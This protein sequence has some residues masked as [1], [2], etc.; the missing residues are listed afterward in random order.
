MQVTKQQILNGAADYIRIEM[1]PHVPDIGFRTILEALA[2]IVQM[3][4]KSIDSIFDNQMLSAVLQEQDG[5][6]DL[7]L[8]ES[9]LVKAIETHGNLE[10]I[11][12][13]IPLLS[14]DEKTLKFSANDIKAL[15]RHIT[16]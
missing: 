7:D 6:Y 8:I 13:K 1:I 14:K 2:A 15:K 12:P 16:Q 5:F 3:A 10:I 11:V 9:A 4:P